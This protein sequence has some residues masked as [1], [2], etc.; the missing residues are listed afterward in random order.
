[1]L[2]WG[3]PFTAVELFGAPLSIGTLLLAVPVFALATAVAFAT[4]LAAVEVVRR[5]TKPPR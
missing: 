2:Y 1:M 4:D 5:V 3:L